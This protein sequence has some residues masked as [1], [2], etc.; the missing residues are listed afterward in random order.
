MAGLVKEFAP[1]LRDYGV[2]VLRDGG[3]D[4][5][6]SVAF[7]QTNLLPGPMDLAFKETDILPVS[8]CDGRIWELERKP[9]RPL[10]STLPD[11]A[12]GHFE[13]PVYV[14]RVDGA[15][16]S[17]AD[18]VRRVTARR[19]S[20]SAWVCPPAPSGLRRG[21]VLAFASSLLTGPAPTGS[22]KRRVYVGPGERPIKSMRPFAA[23]CGPAAISAAAA[24][25]A[26]LT[27]GSGS[28]IVRPAGGAGDPP[29]RGRPS[30]RRP[31]RRAPRRRRGARTLPRQGRGTF[32]QAKRSEEQLAELRDELR[33]WRR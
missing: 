20:G 30:C 2:G 25:Y 6:N 8:M 31:S 9:M 32:L 19:S 17:C 1:K 3:P 12:G 33:A 15:L 24:T 4:A 16:R 13:I 11:K 18:A 14:A 28:R 21:L 29:G 7:A 5:T 26:S 23:G 27:C 10:L 22:S